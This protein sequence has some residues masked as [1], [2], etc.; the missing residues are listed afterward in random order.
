MLCQS[1][2]VNLLDET[3]WREAGRGQYA[4]R[5]LRLNHM[6]SVALACRVA[7]GH[8]LRYAASEGGYCLPGQM[9]V[10]RIL[11]QTFS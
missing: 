6:V 9:L 11:P 8:R 7:A 3:S 10:H 1:E 4:G 2:T 5:K